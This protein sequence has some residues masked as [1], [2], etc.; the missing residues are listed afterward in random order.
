M[1]ALMWASGKGH[2]GVVQALLAKGAD[3]NAVANNGMTALKLTSNEGHPE[4][5]QVLRSAGAER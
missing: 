1:P 2:L 4:V 5:A 3:I